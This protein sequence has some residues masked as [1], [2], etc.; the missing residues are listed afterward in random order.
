MPITLDE[1]MSVVPEETEVLF[2]PLSSFR[3]KE[4]PIPQ[5]Y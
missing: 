4:Q 5:K 3:I 1:E 2:A